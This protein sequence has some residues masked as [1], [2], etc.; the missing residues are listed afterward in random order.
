[1]QRIPR[2]TNTSFRLWRM[3]KS[4]KIDDTKQSKNNVQIKSYLIL[5]CNEIAKKKHTTIKL[6]DYVFLT[7]FKC[8]ISHSKTI[9]TQMQ[10]T[11]SFSPSLSHTQ[12]LF[13]PQRHNNNLLGGDKTISIFVTIYLLLTGAHLI[14]DT[15]LNF[16]K[17]PSN[18]KHHHHCFF[19]LLV[20]WISVSRN[21]V[22]LWNERK[23]KKR[24]THRRIE[25]TKEARKKAK[26]EP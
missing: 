3:Y 24:K 1:M 17:M 5:V 18:A 12:A 19:R 10:M 2:E 23:K 25:T 14:C 9:A 20:R 8:R 7:T 15:H 4:W 16:C 13:F 21:C 11:F 6:C 26:K 22:I